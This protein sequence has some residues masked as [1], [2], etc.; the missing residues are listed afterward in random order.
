MEKDLKE[1]A[2]DPALR[3]V[4]NEPSGSYHQPAMVV[5]LL[6]PAWR[7][8]LVCASRGARPTPES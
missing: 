7:Y 6:T 8:L 3:E 1:A 4:L 5:R 2:P